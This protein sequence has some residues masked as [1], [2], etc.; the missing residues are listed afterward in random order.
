MYFFISL[1]CISI[2][3]VKISIDEYSVAKSKKDPEIQFSRVCPV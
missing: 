2:Q 3:R 1:G